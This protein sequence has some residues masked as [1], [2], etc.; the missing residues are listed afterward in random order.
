MPQIKGTMIRGALKFIKHCQYP[1]GIPAVIASL[2]AEPAAVFAAPILASEWYPY[3]AYSGL[4]AA[5]DR[6]VGRDD[7]SLM[8]TLGRFAARQD[9]SGVFKVISVLA[10]IPRILQSSSI[11]W[12]RYCDAGVFEITAL[13]ADRGTGVVR[14]F[15]TIAPHHES[16]LVGW[17]EGIG[18]AAGA[19]TA[20]VELAR[21]VHRGDAM[22]EYHMRW[23]A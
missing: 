11:F 13:E 3:P 19:K 21:S 22:S 10:S 7:L 18:L 9:L 14:D 20:N 6:Q 15:P 16:M 1:G 8:P 17:I 12:S 5:I 23:T 4:L 2:P